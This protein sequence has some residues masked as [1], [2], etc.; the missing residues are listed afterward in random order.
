M[1]LAIVLACVAAATTWAPAQSVIRAGDGSVFASP[2]PNLGRPSTNS[3][4][5]AIPAV[6][7]DFSGPIPTNE[8]WSSAIWHRDGSYGFPMHPNPLSA[9]FGGG[10]VRVGFDPTPFIDAVA[11][12]HF[13][14]INQPGITLTLDGLNSPRVDVKDSGDWHVTAFQQDGNRSIEM[15][16]ARGLPFAQCLAT[17]DGNGIV[18]ARFGG[19]GIQFFADLGDTIG[20]RIGGVPMAIFAPEGLDWNISGTAATLAIS[21]PTPVAAAI[22]PDATTATLQRFRSSAFAYVTDTR[23]AWDYRPAEAAVRATYTF[24]T[25]PAPGTD[26]TTPIVALYRHQWL[27]S[28]VVTDLGSYT[29]PR[30]EM[31]AAQ[32]NSFTASYPL[33]PMLPA[34]PELSDFGGLTKAQIFNLVDD[35]FRESDLSPAP[36]TYFAGKSYARL[37]HLIWLAERSG[38]QQA[39]DRFLDHLREELTDWLTVV[40][41]DAPPQVFC[42]TYEA[43]QFDASS[44]VSVGA[45]PGGGQAV[46]GFGDGDWIRF[47]NIAFDGRFPN[48]IVLRYASASE[49]S[50]LFQIRVGSLSGPVLA[51]GGIGGTG[52]ENQYIE[53]P[54]G[55][56]PGAQSQLAATNTIF[57]LIDTPSPGELIRLDSFTFDCGVQQP[58]IGFS[59]DPLWNTLLASDPSF[60]F[61]QQLNDH[62]FHFGYFVMAAA[63]VAMRDPD[64][65]QRFGP[66]VE[67]LISDVANHDRADERFPFLRNFDPYAAH[68]YASGHAAFT[69][70]NNQ[71]SS[72]ESMNFNTSLALWGMT[73]GNTKLRDLGLYLAAAETAAIEQ[74]W[75]DADDEVFPITAPLPVSG[76]VWD[77]GAAFST[78]F[79]GDPELI[80][81]I[82][83]LP[84]SA[85]SLYLARH[86]TALRDKIDALLARIGGNVNDWASITLTAL[87]MI[88]PVAALNFRSANP[89]YEVEGGH[90]RA[91]AEHWLGA[92]GVLGIVDP[93]VTA[94]HP[95][96]AV[97]FNGVEH[98]YA[99]WNPGPDEIRVRFSDGAVLCVAGGELVSSLE[100]TPDPC[101]GT[102]LSGDAA[103]DVFDLVEL[104]R[105]IAAAEPAGDWNGDGLLDAQDIT[106]FLTSGCA[107]V[108]SP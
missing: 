52:G 7:P 31:R 27:N 30:G 33:P 62:H 14:D 78:F 2:A 69:I 49:G 10:G 71:E 40:D 61:N 64:W 55:T 3:G 102:D 26:H 87:A 15:T 81:G 76:I 54:L 17:P 83:L 32:T 82:N 73:T 16:L 58:E 91:H 48:R 101:C 56:L 84:I 79:S 13:F 25:Q 1:R 95:A 34:L 43:E 41:P 90:S 98:I 80:H 108:P 77:A 20:V 96:A 36:D 105:L 29:T 19:G 38:H 93:T 46:T 39:A 86:P 85:T 47:D 11:Y 35:V 97:F 44:G 12:Y 106:S 50:G 8:W 100:V 68:S 24:E 37:A 60:G 99:A 57:L 22:L 42:G 72:S 53:L 9:F 5:L 45:A 67:L 66:A 23:I 59:Y 94:N 104:L 88:D 89:F 103:T 74:Y 65:A 4:A 51:E 75:F 28:D 6:T 18:R 70:G 92:F 21:Q 63:H 107:G